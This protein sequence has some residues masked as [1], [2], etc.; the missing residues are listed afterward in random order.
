VIG[1][2]RFVGLLNAAVWLGAAVFFLLGAG[3]AATSEDMQNLLGPKNYPYF[4]AAIAQ[5]IAS[6]F[7]HLYLACATVALLHM[8]GEWLYF[9][10]YPQRFS[11]GLLLSLCLLGLTQD[12]WLQPRLKVLHK[13]LHTQALNPELRES[14]NH[15]FHVTGLAADALEWLALGGLAVYLWGLATPPDVPRF[16]SANKFRS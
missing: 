4:S 6:R 14:A 12:Y 7:F 2:L 13:M 3:P 5:L 10:K 11:L 9:G 15:A 1:L 8:V 16:V